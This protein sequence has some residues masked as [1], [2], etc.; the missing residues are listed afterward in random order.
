MTL[1]TGFGGTALGLLMALTVPLSGAR[2]DTGSGVAI[3]CKATIFT[4]NSTTPLAI[5]PTSDGPG[6]WEYRDDTTGLYISADMP[7][8][9][10][11]T[12]STP[13]WVLMSIQNG[14][15]GSAANV[16]F[17]QNGTAQ[18]TY[19]EYSPKKNYVLECH[20]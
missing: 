19:T 10:L 18:L 13:N 15:S 14:N 3:S 1:F 2:A 16:A 6:H 20:K 11:T 8:P 4:D 7:D 17:E 5:Q 12:G 9:D